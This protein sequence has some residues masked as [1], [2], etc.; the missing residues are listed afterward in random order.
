MPASTLNSFHD[1]DIGQRIYLTA[2]VNNQIV[3]QHNWIDPSINNRMIVIKAIYLGDQYAWLDS[4]WDNALK[5]GA[6]NPSCDPIKNLSNFMYG[7]V[8]DNERKLL[9]CYNITAISNVVSPNIINSNVSGTIIGLFT[10]AC[11]FENE[12]VSNSAFV[13]GK[14]VCY[15]CR[16]VWK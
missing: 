14:Y 7:H 16:N 4:E 5:T 6:L 8:P 10:C 12:N 3:N 1:L 13:N 11:G 15:S 9:Y 2:D